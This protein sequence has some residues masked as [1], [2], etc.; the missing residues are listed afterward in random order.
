MFSMCRKKNL[1]KEGAGAGVLITI[2]DLVGQFDH[3]KENNDDTVDVHLK[4]VSL[5]N[6]AIHTYYWSTEKWDFNGGKAVLTYDWSD[7]TDQEKKEFL[8]DLKKSSG[9][10]TG[11]CTLTHGGGYL[12]ASLNDMITCDVYGGLHYDWLHLHNALRD[13]RWDVDITEIKLDFGNQLEEFYQDGED[14][15]L[16]YD[17]EYYSD[18]QEARDAESWMNEK[19]IRDILRQMK[20]KVEK[21]SSQKI[22]SWSKDWTFIWWDLEGTDYTCYS[23]GYS[24]IASNDKALRDAISK[25]KDPS[26]FQKGV[27]KEVYSLIKKVSGTSAG[28]WM[29]T[30]LT[31]SDLKNNPDKMKKEGIKLNSR[32]LVEFLRMFSGYV[33]VKTPVY[34]NHYMDSIGIGYKGEVGILMCSN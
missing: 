22:K 31:V 24:L 3:Y 6:C 8:E 30:E 13:E 18:E 25:E 1:V 12:H 34:Y 10:G 32:N 33:T 7:F 19:R 16:H 15:Y 28:N 29:D 26:P 5:E 9:I 27:S 14:K 11:S 17:D 2:E 23:N 4:N 20:M 21:I